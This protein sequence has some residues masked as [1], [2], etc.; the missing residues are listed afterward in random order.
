MMML[1]H[2]IRRKFIQYMENKPDNFGLKF[3]VVVDLETKYFMYLSKN[4]DRE[5]SLQLS[6]YVVMKLMDMS[7]FKGKNVTLD[8]FFTSKK[9]ADFL[10]AKGTSI[11]GKMRQNRR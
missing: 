3:W 1:S 2:E 10:L 7:L 8:N 11:V 4:E 5:K 6:K 9:L